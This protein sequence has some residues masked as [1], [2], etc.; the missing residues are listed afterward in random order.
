MSMFG[1]QMA[2]FHKQGAPTDYGDPAAWTVLQEWD[3]DLGEMAVMDTAFGGFAFG[4]GMSWSPDGTVFTALCPAQRTIRSFSC[5]VPFDP[6]S[7]VVSLSS[8]AGGFQFIGGVSMHM[9]QAG[10]QIMWHGGF[11]NF[12]YV[13]ACS[14]YAVVGG[15]L[16]Q[17]DMARTDW[18][19]SNEMGTQY[20]KKDLS[21]AISDGSN[22]SGI[23]KATFTP[24][25]NL[26]SFVIGTL[27][28]PAPSTVNKIIVGTKVSNDGASYYRVNGGVEWFDMSTPDDPTTVTLTS[29]TVVNPTIISYTP[30]GIFIDPDDT[31]IVWLWLGTGSRTRITKCAT[32][33]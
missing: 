33:I 26:D 24:A 20:P 12:L 8:Y 4:G 17:S 23:R 13:R 7:T 18:P 1:P 30:N 5:S 25:G 9:N 3:T 10:T 19:W 16:N 32:N 22:P 14:G 28:N 29:T 21:Y 11:N 31:S 2:T 6:D 27:K 15:G